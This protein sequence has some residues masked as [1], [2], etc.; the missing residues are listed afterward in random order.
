MT[1]SPINVPNTFFLPNELFREAQ[2]ILRDRYELIEIQIETVGGIFCHAHDKLEERDLTLKI[3]P[4]LV[5]GDQKYLEVLRKE[6]IRSHRLAHKNIWRVYS[7]ELVQGLPFLRIELISKK[8]LQNLIGTNP[9]PKVV[10]KILLQ[11][12][13]AL[14]Y[15]YKRKL[16]HGDIRPTAI[17]LDENNNVK[18][19]DFGFANTTTATLTRLTGIKPVGANLYSA[20]E[21]IRGKFYGKASE[22]YAL[23]CIMYELLTEVPPFYTGNLEYQHINEEPEALPE[24]IKKTSDFVYEFV[25]VGLS[26]D[27]KRRLYQLEQIIN[28]YRNSSNRETNNFSIIKRISN[29]ISR[30]LVKPLFKVILL[31]VVAF[32]LGFTIMQAFNHYQNQRLLE[33]MDLNAEDFSPIPGRSFIMGD[34]SSGEGADNRD[35]L[36]TIT[37]TF[38]LSKYEIS[39]KQF[40]LY[41]NA[42][43]KNLERNRDYE[44][45]ELLEGIFSL[46]TGENENYPATGMDWIEACDFCEWL[47][48]IDDDNDYQLPT[49]AQW[50]LAARGIGK[51]KDFPWGDELVVEKLNANTNELRAVG[52]HKQ[53][54]YTYDISGNAAEWVWDYYDANYY[55]SELNS[56]LDPLGPEYGS[57]H[58]IRGGSFRDSP[59]QCG[60]AVRKKAS[61]YKSKLD[62]V[63]F[64]IVQLKART[65][66]CSNTN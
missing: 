39:R 15:A 53:N 56:C 3:I 47:S 32:G 50:E 9:N 37:E 7:L 26:K 57:E 30:N 5:S 33:A 43:E 16:L 29:W 46:K 38:Y 51:Q 11:C 13:D 52:T 25:T 24:N 4:P 31:I 27:A 20:P 17:T 1:N 28:R 18:F 55:R 35:Q 48:A 40:L 61:D 42:R 14:S 2:V 62:E 64:R 8:T 23:A 19:I 45:I 10:E 34:T 60:V 66:K 44:G 54:L 41:L 65:Q 36:I 63:G 59:E 22:Y 6:S 58:V 49:E 12:L 21:I